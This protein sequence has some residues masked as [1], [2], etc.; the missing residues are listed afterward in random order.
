MDTDAIKSAR[1]DLNFLRNLA[2]EG[3]GALAR[4]GA[5]LVTVGAIFAV[6]TFFYFLSFSGVV[7]VP[8]AAEQSAWIAGVALM[9]A[10][11]P[12]IRRRFPQGRTAASRAIGAGMASVGIGLLAAGLGF[13]LAA[14]R[15][16]Q[17]DF[18]L[19]AFPVTLFTLYGAAWSVAYAARRRAWMALVVAG[20][21]AAALLLGFFAG[22]PFVWLVMS[23]GLLTLVAAP[24]YAM[25]KGAA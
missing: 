17:P 15:L 21:F 25:M 16:G 22:S 18:I 2:E 24:G 23:V 8:A 7:A 11:G 1:G 3:P 5:L 20:C 9:I 4:D 10:A 14:W 19:Q 12:F 6:V 13:V